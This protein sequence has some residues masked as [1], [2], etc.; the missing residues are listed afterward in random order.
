MD[1]LPDELVCAILGHL[2]R[3]WLSVASTTCRQWRACAQTIASTH[4][5]SLAIPFYTI[6]KAAARGF[7]SL[8]VWLRVQMGHPWTTSTLA[9]A[10]RRGHFHLVD[11][12]CIARASVPPCPMDEYVAAAAI[13]GGGSRMLRK[14][15]AHGCP[16]GPAAATV[17]VVL[18]DW[19]SLRVL[20][21][22]GCTYDA[23]TVI[24]A[25]ALR[26]RHIIKK[27]GFHVDDVAEAAATL[28]DVAGD[29]DGSCRLSCLRC[30]ARTF[31]ASANTK[32]LLGHLIDGRPFLFV[33]RYIST[34]LTYPCILSIC[35]SSFIMFLFA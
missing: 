14:V 1:A 5:H 25:V 15:R 8:V 19:E 21:A 20:A 28:S 33:G 11:C 6:D 10:A 12:M 4:R 31:A 32:H 30:D 34:S 17:A 23:L 9:A 16:W 13:A 26:R 27:L 24:A 3:R 29:F 22:G 18:N 7:A 35:F 2:R